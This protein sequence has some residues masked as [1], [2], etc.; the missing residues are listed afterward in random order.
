MYVIYI[1]FECDIFIGVIFK[2]IV[3]MAGRYLFLIEF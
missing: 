2:C 1:I 3:K